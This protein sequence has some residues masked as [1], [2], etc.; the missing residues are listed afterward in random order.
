MPSSIVAGVIALLLG[1][2]VLGAISGENSFLSNG[3]FN[4][5]ILDVWSVIPGMFINAV[6]LR[7]RCTNTAA[8]LTSPG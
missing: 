5:L 7:Q 6:F 4:Q 8:W 2:D 3:L 1:P